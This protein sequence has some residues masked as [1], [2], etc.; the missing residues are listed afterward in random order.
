MPWRCRSTLAIANVVVDIASHPLA[1]H[2]P[3]CGLGRAL[4]AVGASCLQSWDGP[5]STT[6]ST[7]AL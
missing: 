5:T 4:G 3:R 6:A 7:T 1:T 2:V